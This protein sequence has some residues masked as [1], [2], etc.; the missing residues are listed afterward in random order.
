MASSIILPSDFDIKNLKVGNV[1]TLDN[2][3]RTVYVS[4]NGAPLIVQT[5]EMFTTSGLKKWEK[6]NNGVMDVSY[7]MELSFK[8]RDERPTL[9][10]FYDMLISMDKRF[11]EEG[12]KQSQSF[13]K[14]KISSM[15]VIDEKYTDQVR[16]SK[17]ESGN[18]TDKYPP[19]FRLKLPYRNNKF[20][21]EVYNKKREQIDITE[22]PTKGARIVAIVQC[23][24]LWISGGSFGCTW[25]L[26]QVQVTPPAYIKGFAFKETNEELEDDS[27]AKDEDTLPDADEIKQHALV[28][29]KPPVAKNTTV[30]ADS[31][32]EE[33][34]EEEEE[35][36]DD[37]TR[38][39]VMKRKTK[40]KKKKK[41]KTR[42]KRKSSPN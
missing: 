3:G 17:D 39:W 40:K 35:D 30:I 1:R 11:K 7:T 20:G 12:M 26:I 25:K 8:G 31:D 2:G 24:G 28:D 37:K 9:Q 29:K 14:K 5:P 19:T 33:E 38:Y 41:K 32:E 23:L 6:E 13:F 22:V 36:E 21:M 34:E 42:K 16:Y 4:Y 10:C 18:I 15:E 27:K